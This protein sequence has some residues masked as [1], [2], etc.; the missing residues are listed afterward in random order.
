MVLTF[1]YT[2]PTLACSKLCKM[3]LYKFDILYFY[4]IFP[5]IGELKF[6]EEGFSKYLGFGNEAET[7]IL[8]ILTSIWFL[9]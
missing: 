4:A 2:Q 8:S 1:I 6:T 7:C 3:T 5:N 9:F